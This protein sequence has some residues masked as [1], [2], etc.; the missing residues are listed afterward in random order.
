[1]VKG[2]GGAT[3]LLAYAI[4]SKSI[5][6]NQG[7]AIF[8]ADE[9]NLEDTIGKAVEEAKIRWVK[10]GRTQNRFSHVVDELERL[11]EIKQ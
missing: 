2:S 11:T 1:M 5:V 4:E 3:D 10:E 8:I 9:T 6:K 7:A